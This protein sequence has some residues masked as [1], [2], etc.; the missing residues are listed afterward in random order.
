MSIK[1]L[2]ATIF[3]AA[4]GLGINT[5]FDPNTIEGSIFGSIFVIVWCVFLGI[6]FFVWA[7]YKKKLQ[8]K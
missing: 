4:V 6:G 8:K 7:K 1:G 5:L 3:W 2:L